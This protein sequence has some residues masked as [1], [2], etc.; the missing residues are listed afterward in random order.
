M[1]AGSKFTSQL[2][3]TVASLV[4]WIDSDFA[5]KKLKEMDL[6]DR[7]DLIRTVPF[8]ALHL[9]CLAVFIV[10]WSW[11]AVITA[12]VLYFV[13]MFA[14]T[15]FYHRYFSHKTFH[16][17]RVAQFLFA[18]L[19]ASAVQRG[20]LWWAYIH[21][22]HHQH[23]D[24]EGD[25][26]SP[27]Q[28]GF[29]WSHIGWITSPRNF[30]TDYNRVRDLAKF[31][32]LVFLNRF[33]TLVP[34][35]LAVGLF[36]FGKVLEWYVPGAGTTGVQMLVWGFFVSTTVL[37]HATASINSFAHL[38][39][40]RR[41][42]TGDWSRNNFLLALITLGEGWHNNHHKYM[43]TMRAGIRWWEIDITFYVLK[44]MSWM[45]IIWNV[46]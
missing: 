38:F 3:K 44:M 14:I 41:F 31:P 29:W 42:Q 10:G 36:F 5:S 9:M 16:T 46:K 40:R 6:P 39:G 7:V 35:A 23:S 22:H 11:T 17:S 19:G 20:P 1:L 24:K 34:T 43:S 8:I 21:R 15:G 26:H 4:Q 25:F 13:R 33:D 27:I 30:P 45:R 28:R 2:F 12:I 37:F 32:E 18:V